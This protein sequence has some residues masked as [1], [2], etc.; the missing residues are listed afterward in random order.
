MNNDLTDITI[1]GGD[2]Q[3]APKATALATKCAFELVD[4]NGDPVLGKVQ[5]DFTFTPTPATGSISAFT[6]DGAGVYSVTWTLADVVGAQSL[7][8][9]WTEK[10][11][12]VTFNATAYGDAAD[13]VVEFATG[14]AT[15]LKLDG[16]NSV[17]L[18]ARVVDS[19]G[20]TVENFN[21]PDFMFSMTGGTDGLASF[22]G[23][24]DFIAIPV[25]NGVSNANAVLTSDNTTTGT[26]KVEGQ[27][28]ATTPGGP[29]NSS[30]PKDIPVKDKVL[31]SITVTI[32]TTPAPVL[33]FVATTSPKVAQKVQFKAMGKFCPSDNPTCTTPDPTL[34]ENIT[35]SIN[36]VSSD[37]TKGT[38]DAAG[39]FAAISQGATSVTATDG[40]VT[41]AA[42]A[43][44]VQPPAAVT[45]TESLLP[46]TIT[47]GQTI[48]FGAAGVVTGGTGDGFNY[49]V[50]PTNGGDATAATAA[51][52]GKVTVAATGT[53]AGSYTVTVTD[54]TSGASD[55]YLF[56]VPMILSPTTGQFKSNETPAFTISGAPAGTITVGTLP[57]G[58]ASSMA[59]TGA[60]PDVGTLTFGGITTN[61]TNFALTFTSSA[62]GLVAAGLAP[63]SSGANAYSV[64]PVSDVTGCVV[65][66]GTTNGLSGA[67][68]VP[69]N[70]PV[71][72]QTTVTGGTCST[73]GEG[74]FAFLNLAAIT[75]GYNFSVSMAGYYPATFN[76][77]TF[78]GTV[79]LTPMGAND[80]QISGILREWDGSGATVSKARVKLTGTSHTAET[81]SGEDGSYYFIV[82]E[83][84]VTETFTIEAF[85]VGY[86]PNA[87]LAGSGKVT[88]VTVTSGATTTQDV[89]LRPITKISVTPT[90]LG[91]AGPLFL[92]VGAKAG[93]TPLRADLLGDFDGISTEKTVSSPVFPDNFSQLP[94]P[95][96]EYQYTYNTPS[97]VEME[98]AA[99]V[100]SDPAS[101]NPTNTYAA[102]RDYCY[103]PS[104]MDAFA[105]N[106][107]IAEGSAGTIDGPIGSWGG[108]DYNGEMEMIVK[109]ASITVAASA[110]GEPIHRVDVVL[111][112]AEV[113]RA[114]TNTALVTG[115]TW[116][117]GFEIYDVE[118]E[119]IT[120]ATGL[121]VTLAYDGATVPDGS[122]STGG[123]K[124]YTA[125]SLCSLVT[126]INA[127]TPIA[128]T[129]TSWLT[130]AG[131]TVSFTMTLTGYR[132]AFAVSAPNVTPVV[133]SISLNPASV[134]VNSGA[135]TV[136]VTGVNMPAFDATTTVLFDGAAVTPTVT[137][138]TTLTFS[139]PNSAVAATKVVS[140]T[141]GG[142]I[143][144]TANFTYYTS[145]GGSTGGDGGT[146]IIAP[147]AQFQVKDESIDAKQITIMLGEKI[148]FLDKSTGTSL[149][150]WE[151]DFGDDT[152]KLVGSTDEF[153]NPEYEYKEVGKYTV[154]LKVYGAGGT[155]EEKKV[156]FVVVNPKVDAPVCAFTSSA[157]TIKTGES[158]TFT[159]TTPQD[160]DSVVWR[161]NGVPV[162]E[163]ASFAHKFTAAGSYTVKMTVTNAAGSC[164]KSET[165][166]VKDDDPVVVNPTADFSF[167]ANGLAV[168]FT[169]LSTN[170][171]TQTWNFGDNATSTEKN[172]AHQ[173]AASGNF[174]VMLTVTDA[175][176]KTAEM[177]KVVSVTSSGT[178]G[179]II[180]GFTANVSTGTRPLNVI[181]TD[182][183][184]AVS[185]ITSWNWTFGDGA[186]STQKNP[187]HVFENVGTY[188]TMLTV[189]GPDGTDRFVMT[190][191]VQAPKQ[192]S[193]IVNKP[194]AMSPAN[195]ATDI[196]L[197][198]ILKIG[199]YSDGENAYF[200]TIWEISD[201]PA[202]GEGSVLWREENTKTELQVPRFILEADGKT[203]YWRARFVDTNG[204]YSDW[205]DV[206]SF[207]TVKRTAEDQDGNGMNDDQQVADPYA[208]FPGVPKGQLLKAV[209]AA[210]GNGIWGVQGVDK[211]ADIVFLQ[212]FDNSGITLPAK[213]KMPWGLIGFKLLTAAV[214]DGVKITIHFSEAVSENAQWFAYQEVAG[215]QN[216]SVYS[217]FSADRKSVTLTLTDGGAGDLDNLQNGYIVV[218]LMGFGEVESEVV[219]V[220]GDGG[221]SDTCF[222]QSAAGNGAS[223]LWLLSLTGVAAVA[224]RIRRK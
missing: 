128:L 101:R 17:Q 180:A 40:T 106:V 162:S 120:G 150:K 66:A 26:A 137:S 15:Y 184:T 203:F 107:S 220:D 123:T 147:Y 24:V 75:G 87:T 96:V 10:S 178:G 54:V 118:G 64:I 188:T 38:M 206:F 183:S 138:A 151:W 130:Q 143:T 113:V 51:V 196:G 70:S 221:G 219:V 19:L 217:E 82:P 171:A 117:Y 53:F 84:K 127:N 154:I 14:S 2:A 145:G 213:T 95:P 67:N 89:S 103:V 55:T 46:S 90:L 115:S 1:Q 176:G 99:D 58:A 78:T 3:T 166:T 199:P 4:T 157:T 119:P 74:H 182:T 202:F 156:D 36:W 62:P 190:I 60:S 207:T 158:V 27:V 97:M 28:A 210:I 172:P 161:V 181:F 52:D 16:S 61:P 200:K 76:S 85:R 164:S 30:T 34:D 21:D 144:K 198:P 133:P 56:K 45:I 189:A 149:Y 88:G 125:P 77:S 79:E 7:L 20:Q 91:P 72:A 212:A 126:A 13:V 131:G 224:T 163:E 170:Y 153:K 216:F 187:T 177:T 102:S 25:V 80:A 31:K 41:S 104:M 5:A 132:A 92:N 116:I 100:T 204:L 134:L 136:T 18:T 152:E 98:I 135:K 94:G 57:G 175:S 197:M 12:S 185:G 68:V 155:D 201:D 223:L 11:D 32:P 195:G 160:V 22:T 65:E 215:W 174:V 193:E 146:T 23:G 8:V 63:V 93:T 29:I 169:N 108:G 109:P 122:F 191:T 167:V 179:L 165:I 81:Y 49:A 112:Q 43:M 214:G 71:A 73:N 205:S 6:E 194:T 192:P 222:I 142:T 211:V 140:V 209:K 50:A 139:A 124:I 105:K 121:Q 86:L 114:V 141:S 218:P 83:G 186:T 110:S 47:A 39:V 168:T 9:L 129:P 69:T 159:N 42:T 37:P 148:K 59:F 208:A 35:T 111:Y 33:P 173:Y 44:S 48:D